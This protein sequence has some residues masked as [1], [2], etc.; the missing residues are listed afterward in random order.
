MTAEMIKR[1]GFERGYAIM[2]TGG[3]TQKIE[4]LPLSI[5]LTLKLDEA[6]SGYVGFDTFSLFEGWL[7]RTLKSTI[8]VHLLDP[9]VD[10]LTM[11]EQ[12]DI[13]TV[14]PVNDVSL[15]GFARMIAD[16]LRGHL[17]ERGLQCSARVASVELQTTSGDGVRYSP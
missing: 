9:R 7:G 1:Y 4:C 10:D 11:L 14:V 12:L 5:V 15:E 6:S 16:R 2:L 3:L 13:A 17:T 8:Y